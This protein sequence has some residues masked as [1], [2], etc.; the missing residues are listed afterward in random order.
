MEYKHIATFEAK[1]D[2]S[3]KEKLDELVFKSETITLIERK[4]G[5]IE[6]HTKNSVN[7]TTEDILRKGL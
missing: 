6:V 2:N 4:N 7:Y 3:L 1:V 5:F